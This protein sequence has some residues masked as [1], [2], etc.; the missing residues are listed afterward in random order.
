MPTR[1]DVERLAAAYRDVRTL[2]VR[3]LEQLW[4][5]L[6]LDDPMEVRQALE[7]LLPDLTTGYGE[8]AAT[9][10]ADIYDEMR[11]ESNA[12]GSFTPVLAGSYAIEAVRANARWAI[13]PLF[14]SRPDPDAALSRLAGE[15]DRMSLQPGRET[16]AES[17]RRDPA[18]P[19]WARVPT[20]PET[21]AWCL[22][23]ASRGAIYRS[24][25]TA[26]GAWDWHRDCDCT[27]TPFWPKDPYPDGY[28]PDGLYE[29]YAEARAQAGSGDLKTVLSKLRELQ[30]IH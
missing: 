4:R 24:R 14:S 29:V 18:K 11:A 23:L 2:A 25:E 9:V 22:S 27:P 1:A 5:S 30:G 12:P 3:D 19:R 28:D 16:I 13:G 8:L 26:G 6:R 10:A 21:C 17:V 7:D 15:V 20:G